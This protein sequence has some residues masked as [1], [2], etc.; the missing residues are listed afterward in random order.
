ME[1]SATVGDCAMWKLPL[2]HLSGS[3]VQDAAT[4]CRVADTVGDPTKSRQASRRRSEQPSPR[5]Q[6]P[7]RDVTAAEALLGPTALPWSREQ[8]VGRARRFVCFNRDELTCSKAH[9]HSD[10]RGDNSLVN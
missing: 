7:T 9:R 2:H 8:A 5:A 3:L 1:G 6:A 4:N 10:L